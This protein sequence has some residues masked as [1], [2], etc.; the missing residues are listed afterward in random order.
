[1][2]TFPT[3]NPPTR[4][5]HAVTDPRMTR[6]A[7]A[8]TATSPPLRHAATATGDLAAAIKAAYADVPDV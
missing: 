7:E 8:V 6:F 3:G 2:S 5:E 4:T 1:M